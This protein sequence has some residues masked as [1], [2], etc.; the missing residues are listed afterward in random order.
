MKLRFAM[1]GAIFGL[2]LLMIMSCQDEVQTGRVVVKI[3]DEPFPI[4]L[5]EKASVTISKV[6]IRVAGTEEEPSDSETGG[7]ESSF[8]VIFDDSHDAILTDLR[9]GVTDELANLEIPADEYD[10]VRIHVTNASITLKDNGTIPVN[11]PSG[12]QTGVK[13]F[14]KPGVILGGNQTAEVLLD[15]NLE[16]SFVPI[17][18]WSDPEN[19]ERFNFKPVIRAVNNLQTGM[20]KGFIFSDMDPLEDVVVSVEEK[21]QQLSTLTEEDGSYAILGIPVGAYQITADKE[22]YISTTCAEVE[23]LAGKATEKDFVLGKL[24]DFTQ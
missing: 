12:E 14:I 9:N 23:V 10:L 21:D 1:P 20:I 18:E 16:K 8:I 2:F 11:V 5:I 4:T 19:I 15:F 22:G 6:E 3:T 24:P 13:V 7:E 17:G